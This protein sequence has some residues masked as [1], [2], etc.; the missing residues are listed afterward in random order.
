[1]KPSDSETV[2]SFDLLHPEIRR[3][4]WEQQWQELRDVQDRAIRTIL[5]SEAD[6]LIA[7]ATAAGKTEAAFLPVLTAIAGRDGEGFG[8]IYIS[9]LKALINDQFRRLDLLCERMEIDV[10]RWHG[11]AP[12]SA[13][14]R[15]R[16]DP[17]GVAL[18]TP[19]S[20][21]AM[22]VRRP[23]DARR[24]LGNVDFIVIDELHAFLRGPRGLHLAS[25]L[26]RIDVLN[27]KRPRRIGLSA[28]IG[29]LRQG[30]EWLAPGRGDTVSV[31]ESPGGSPEL[32]LQIRG[33]VHP[34][35][36]RGSASP[37]PDAIDEIVDHLFSSLRETSNLVFAGSRKRV[38]TIADRLRVKSE[39]C[40]VPNEF[41]P[42]HGSLSKSLRE[43]L[44][45]R[46]REGGLPTTA[47]ATTTLEL[48]VDIGAVKSVAQIGPPRSLSSLRQRLGRSGRRKDTP[49]ILRIYLDVPYVTA[50]SPAIDRLRPDIVMSVAAINLLIRKF[51]EPAGEDPSV[52]TVVLHQTLSIIAQRGG[53]TPARLYDAICGAGPLA[54]L[55]KAD[56][57]AMLR[58]AASPETALIE[59][60]PDGNLMLSTE[61][62]RIVEGRDFYA[63]FETDEEWRLVAAGRTLGTIPI[64]NAVGVGTVLA[65][66]GRRWIV[67]AVDDRAKVVEVVSSPAGKVPEFDSLS[68]EAIHSE[69]AREMLVVYG[70]SDVPRYLDESAGRLLL[71]GRSAFREF[72]LASTPFAYEGSNT[73]VALWEGA[74]AISLTAIAF[75]M[76]GYDCEPEEIGLVFR[77]CSPDDVRA[78]ASKIANTP[79]TVADLASFVKNL[80]NAKYDDYVSENLLRNLWQ[81]RHEGSICHVT[82][83]LRSLAFSA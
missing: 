74:E 9:P 45:A 81:K 24:L 23:A 53:E 29:D 70:Q 7:A 71:E 18:I 33:Y 54:M 22:M 40:G 77:G 82:N 21:E 60:A 49:A 66:A 80:R 36:V 51:V 1:M 32:R 30:A 62:E 35:E 41:F 10:V 28:T 46:L 64:S 76:A 67:E 72:D 2:G 63:I 14:Q 15:A 37:K 55:S 25:L 47:V 65:F 39:T 78:A 11:D 68:G 3:W 5:Q 42:H 48:G 20:I 75:T 79:F 19:E 69:L 16:R 4:I 43:E 56:Y 13:K 57:V 6:V 27:A 59:Q 73:F 61:G 8:A 12:Q 58:H 31:V 17:K 38:E 83:I 44:E 34:P 52:A 50:D 26:Q